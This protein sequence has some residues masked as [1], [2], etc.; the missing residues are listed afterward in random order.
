ME[1][2][3]ENGANI[4]VDLTFDQV[5]EELTKFEDFFTDK[6]SVKL[7]ADWLHEDYGI[8][9]AA[10]RLALKYIIPFVL[11]RL[12]QLGKVIVQ[13]WVNKLHDNLTHRPLY[14]KL[15]RTLL[16]TLKTRT[17]KTY[18]RA[19]QVADPEQLKQLQATP[20]WTQLNAEQ[21]GL[22]H[23]LLAQ[24]KNHQQQLGISNN[25]H[26]LIDLLSF[27]LDLKS[28]DQLK[29]QAE[30]VEKGSAI[31]LTYFKQH[32]DLI[33]RDT[34]L[35]RLDEFYDQET[36][37]SWW[38]ISG[39]GGIGKSRLA[40]ES[41][42][43][44]D[45]LWDVGFLHASKL[46][47]PDALHKWTPLQPTI[48]VIDYAASHSKQIA[49]WLDHIIQHKDD[50]LCPVRILILE[51]EYKNQDWW[52][53]LTTGSSAALVRKNA[54][55]TAEPIELAPLN[56]TD[57]Q[58][59]L[60]SFL[61]NLEASDNL[62]EKDH[63][64]W[65]TIHTITTQGSPLFLGMVA[66]ALAHNSLADI[67]QWQ[68]LDLLDNIYS[69]EKQAWQRQLDDLSHEQY[70]QAIDLLAFATLIGGFDWEKE[71]DN[72]QTLLACQLIGSEK[73]IESAMKSI[74]I[75]AGHQGGYL[76]P[77]LIG[78]YF[79]LQH[80]ALPANKPTAT[81]RRILMHALKLAPNNT[82]QSLHRCATDYPDNKTAFTWWQILLTA[83]L[84][85]EESI[86]QHD[87]ALRIVNQLT[88]H[89][90]YL[91]PL[92]TWLP[93]LLQTGNHYTKATALN[94]MAIIYL[95]LSN[96]GKALPLL[97]KALNIY[98][99]IE[100]KVGEGTTLNNIS[101]IYKAKGDYHTALDYLEQSLN[102]SESIGDKVGEG[103]T[104]N[105][106]SRIYSDKG[107]IDTALS[108]LKKSLKIK[109]EI[110]DKGGL[111]NMADI[112]FSKGDKDTALSYFE[113][114][115]VIK[116]EI[117]DKAGV[118]VALNNISQIY[119]AKGDNDTALRYLKQSLK[120]KEEI[121]DKVGKSITLNNMATIVLSK[122][123]K[124][125]ASGYLEQ[126][127]AIQKEIDN[128]AGLCNTLFNIGHIYYKNNQ[129]DKAINTWL[130]AYQ[131]A[132][133]IELK[134]G[135]DA[136]EGLGTQLG[137][138]DGLIGWQALLDERNS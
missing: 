119:T 42:S 138:K 32:S 115:L 116:E 117:G 4:S 6:D 22:V 65:G 66:I 136:L 125:T 45:Y 72:I 9:K 128:K 63:T 92:T 7:L 35:N 19:M 84:N 18:Q 89:C 73:E 85:E 62:P 21:Q 23:L 122:G 48:I 106:I 108:Y 59:A 58:T 97:Q 71:E 16:D 50:Y 51:R 120:I 55:Y 131:I 101:Q 100:N 75:L 109:E 80:Y 56:K 36:M 121:G 33:G 13:S 135:L 77:D 132:S 87:V 90:H 70:H 53:H 127:L 25:L 126:S 91:I 34:Q 61:Y 54:F 47:V 118:G 86:I 83:S 28:V 88:L 49:N 3:G 102:I 26:H 124:D 94:Q 95:H 27:D 11:N 105:N 31:W 81:K 98:K 96:Y 129:K 111:N 37:F 1:N 68:H 103:T 10:S 60:A 110:G 99:G 114:S 133:S 64:I 107:D 104:L 46:D 112:A 14:E 130:D 43:R 113:Q 78:E 76:Q 8:N 57:Q 137:L 79:L 52:E 67:R 17:D 82:Q 20:S 39:A 123:D 38:A 41:I 44:H 30:T 74:E 69:R 29:S 12:S 2:Q 40:L 93:A 15:S 24:E 5:I 134:R